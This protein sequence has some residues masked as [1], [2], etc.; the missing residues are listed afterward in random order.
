M[1][2]VVKVAI[3]DISEGAFAARALPDAES[4]AGLQASI[5][6]CGL[7]SPV[8]VRRVSLNRYELIAGARRF[9]AVKA[10][11]ETHIDAFV[12][13]AFD[14]DAALL[15][16]ME[17]VQREALSFF[18]E[19]RA[20]SRLLDE[21][22]FSRD[23]LSRLL[24]MSAST[25]SNKLRLLRLPDEIKKRILETDLTERHARALLKLKQEPQQSSALEKCVK[26]GLS[27]RQLEA[28]VEDMLSKEVGKRSMK[29]LYRD[30][31]M[32]INAILDAVKKLKGM[33][34]S[35]KS[36]IIRREDGV[37]IIVS[38]PRG[39]RKVVT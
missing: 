13:G 29:R 11:N 20:L 31:R 30:D 17:N 16:L 19:A 21:H 5:R 15:S 27:V 6:E 14:R 1:R 32:F 22:G 35:A 39:G 2:G 23:E 10:L 25:L 3:A 33:G 38:L 36:R 12:L 18:D 37:D 34:V 26:R 9:V 24:G 8:L 4:V 7:L 28:L